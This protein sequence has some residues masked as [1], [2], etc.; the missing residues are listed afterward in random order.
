MPILNNDGVSLRLTD[1]ETVRGAGF[2]QRVGA[3]RKVGHLELAAL[4]ILILPR[5]SCLGSRIGNSAD[6]RLVIEHRVLHRGTMG[7]I[8]HICAGHRAAGR[9]AVIHVS[10]AFQRHHVSTVERVSAIGIR[11][12]EGL[13]SGPVSLIPANS[14]DG[15]RWHH[16]IDGVGDVFATP[17]CGGH[18]LSVRLIAL[19]CRPTSI[20]VLPF[21]K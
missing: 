13:R 14:E 9:C 20:G 12:I 7:A 18:L 2:L 21:Q 10:V 17:T 3:I 6:H 4:R 19:V 8:L 5:V 15:I 11:A 1:I 16:R